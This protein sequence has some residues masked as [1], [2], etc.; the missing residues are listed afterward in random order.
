MTDLTRRSLLK[1]LSAGAIASSSLSVAS[2]AFA[3]ERD[4]ELDILCWE[5]YNS[6]EVLDP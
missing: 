2:K 1:A 3:G 5:G 4:K 6:A